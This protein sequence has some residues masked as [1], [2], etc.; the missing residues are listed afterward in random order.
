MPW[1][2]YRSHRHTGEG[3]V[4][5]RTNPP[6]E[7]ALLISAIL[8]VV[9]FADLVLGVIHLPDHYAL[10]ALVLSGFIMI[11]ASVVWGL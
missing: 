11:L 1:R 10:W 8:W 7:A 5:V 4:G 9:G 6:T 2:R 3:G